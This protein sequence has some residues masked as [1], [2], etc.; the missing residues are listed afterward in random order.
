IARLNSIDSLRTYFAK[1]TSGTISLR[2]IQLLEDVKGHVSFYQ[3]SGTLD[4]LKN[5]GGLRLIRRRN[6]VDSIQSYDQQIKRMVLRDQ[7]EVEEMRY[8]I[9]LSYKFVDG[10]VL[11]NIYADTSY[12]NNH[13]L[14]TDIPKSITI[15]P[16]YVSE[17]LNSLAT[18]RF[19][20]MNNMWLQQN[21]RKKAEDLL[22]LIKKEYHLK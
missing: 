13:R 7:Y 22:A 8:T 5:A 14:R 1:N 9:R 4:Q 18:F 11:S 16:Q 2:G 15:N 20:V 10:I 17:Y 3:N 19:V 12:Y 21:I 6:V